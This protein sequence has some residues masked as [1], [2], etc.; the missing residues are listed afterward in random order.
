LSRDHPLY[1][2]IHFNVHIMITSNNVYKCLYF[3][4]ITNEVR[5]NYNLNG[6][7]DPRRGFISMKN[8]DREEMSPVNV[9]G[10]LR[11]EFFRRKDRYEEL[12]PDGEFTVAISSHC[13]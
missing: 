10:D 3:T 5:S 4:L 8:K 9:R 2:Y 7:E 11:E 6:D 1:K 12:K 13:S